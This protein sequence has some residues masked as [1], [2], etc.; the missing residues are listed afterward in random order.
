MYEDSKQTPHFHFFT[1]IT[2][3]DTD[4]ASTLADVGPDTHSHRNDSI[5]YS[6]D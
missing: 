6:E 2:T 5:K 3:N 1:I 4:H